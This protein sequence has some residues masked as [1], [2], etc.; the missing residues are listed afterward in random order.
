MIILDSDHLRVLQSG[1]SQASSLEA[2]LVAA[3]ET[4]ATTI[5]N[6]EEGLR[7]WLSE[8]N[9]R[10]P[11]KQPPYYD[12]L[13]SLLLYF[14]FWNVLPFDAAALAEYERLAKLKI[15][16]IGTMDLKIAAITISNDA[17]LLSANLRHLSLV[18]GLRVE[19]WISQEPPG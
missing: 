16:R 8:I 10:A 4:V 11:A 7:G 13:R 2:R 18:P 19:D 14:S 1:G 3:G 5:I 9:K 6:V 15:R 12:R 17:R